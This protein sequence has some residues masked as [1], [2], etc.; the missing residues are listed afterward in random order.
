MAFDCCICEKCWHSIA[1]A[2]VL[3]SRIKMK[4]RMIIKQKQK[5]INT[6]NCENGLV[7]FCQC[8]AFIHFGWPRAVI[9]NWPNERLF[10]SAVPF[11]S[12]CQHQLQIEFFFSFI[13]I[14]INI[15]YSFCARLTG[16]HNRN[17]ELTGIQFTRNWFHCNRKSL[18]AAILGSNFSF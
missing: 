10:Q 7:S 12:R 18:T 6:A 14:I 2:T 4:E 1:T 3:G 5:K 17:I 9:F 13:I 15:R 8:F 11:H 16:N